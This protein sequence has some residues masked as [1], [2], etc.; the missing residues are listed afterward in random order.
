MEKY[1]HDILR[2][3]GILEKRYKRL[4]IGFMF[5]LG[6]FIGSLIWTLFKE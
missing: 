3:I 5:L 6:W 2:M 4:K 1:Q